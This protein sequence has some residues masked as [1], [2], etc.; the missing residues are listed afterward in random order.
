MAAEYPL[1][2][3]TAWM[4]HTAAVAEAHYHMVRDE[5]FDRA[6]CT[7]TESRGAQCGAQVAQNAAQQGAAGKRS[8]AQTKVETVASSALV[9]PD[10]VECASLQDEGMGPVGLEPTLVLPKRILSPP[11][12]PIPPRARGRLCL[13]QDSA[14]HTP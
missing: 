13:G 12:L 6:A 8:V 2:V 14:V 10:A 3:C 1:A 9:Q 7:P 11:R 5:D 4:W